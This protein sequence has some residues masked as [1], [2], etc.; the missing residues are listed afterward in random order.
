MEGCVIWLVG[1]IWAT[2]LVN[3]GQWLAAVVVFFGGSFLAFL[4]MPDGFAE[5]IR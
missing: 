2:H 1:V 3:A 4:F 5:G